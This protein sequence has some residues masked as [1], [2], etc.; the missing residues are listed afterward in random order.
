MIRHPAAL[1]LA[2]GITLALFYLMQTL[3]TL[4]PPRQA[5]APPPT[6]GSEVRSK[7]W[8]ARHTKAQSSSR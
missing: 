3:I 6:V 1:L 4:S 8:T 7:R 5:A 2:V